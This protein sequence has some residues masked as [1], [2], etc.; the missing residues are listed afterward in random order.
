MTNI[1][2]YCLS[3]DAVAEAPTDN[4]RWPLASFPA[5]ADAGRIHL[6]RGTGREDHVHLRDGVGPLGTVSGPHG[7]IYERWRS[8]F[9]VPSPVKITRVLLNR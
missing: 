7:C 3:R 4:N 1:R 2:C 8:L 5:E 9:F 6:R